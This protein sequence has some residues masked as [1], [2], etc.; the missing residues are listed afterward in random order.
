MCIQLLLYA[1]MA[2]APP[3]PNLFFELNVF[4]Y[5]IIIW[6]S[7]LIFPP[8]FADL[9]KCHHRS[10][11]TMLHQQRQS[12]TPRRHHPSKKKREFRRPPPLQHLIHCPKRCAITLFA[13]ASFVYKLGCNLQSIIHRAK[14]AAYGCHQN[15]CT[16]RCARAT[17]LQSVRQ[18]SHLTLVRFDSNSY[19]MEVDGHAL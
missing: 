11:G 1:T 14:R 9:L 7:I 15:T 5:P 6:M 2:D 4:I 16:R 19:L 17:A 13:A 18:G 8:A 3:S 12:L 10:G